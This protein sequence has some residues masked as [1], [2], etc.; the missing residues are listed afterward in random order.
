VNE[1][2]RLRALV[3]SHGVEGR[4]RGQLRDAIWKFLRERVSEAELAYLY[5]IDILTC[6]EFLVRHQ[7][8]EFQGDSTQSIILKRLPKGAV[9]E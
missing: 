9:D 4:D 8:S 3:A 1:W 6:S 2:G 5:G 7:G